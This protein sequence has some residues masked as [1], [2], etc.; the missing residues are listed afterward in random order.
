V[1]AL[2]RFRRPD[3]LAPALSR[4]ARPPRRGARD[5]LRASLHA[6]VWEGAG[7]EIVGAC[8]G[9]AM[10]AAW[11][12]HLGAGPA[13]TGLLASLP[14]LASA[15]QLPAAC[16]TSRLGA[17]RAAVR[18]VTASRQ[19]PLLLA[20]LAFAPLPG[21]TA[22]AVLTAVAVASA[23]L[24]V[25]GNNA[26]TTWMGEL[27]PAPVRGRYFGRRTAVCTVAGAAAS[28]LAGAYVDAAKARGREGAALG[29]LALAAWTAGLACTT[30]MRRQHDP[31]VPPEPLSLRASLTPLR[32]AATRRLLAWNAAWNAAVGLGGGFFTVFMLRD[33]AMGLALTGAYTAATAAVRVL[34]APRWGRVID[35]LGAPYVV[36]RCSY[37]IAA[38][39]LLWLFARPGALWPVAVDAAMTGVLWAG[40]SLATFQLPLAA[41]PRVGRA[42]HLAAFATAG[43]AGFA[44]AASLAAWLA[45]AL[46]AQVGVAGHAFANLQILFAL[47]AAARL[48][49]AMLARRMVPVTSEAA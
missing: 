18:L 30:L 28:L 23:L 13:A 7:A 19:G 8:S 27:V 4:D 12:R 22:R 39:P 15:A 25:A 37:G 29:L 31:G 3:A 45:G 32:R 35:R 33:L 26:W 49:V 11:A 47:S 42:H 9:G 2:Q 43:G 1:A 34:A 38:I 21:A 10:L 44:L 46:P 6:S 14:S 36:A 40:H 16:L 5:R 17:R 41:S 20:L 24:G 48:G